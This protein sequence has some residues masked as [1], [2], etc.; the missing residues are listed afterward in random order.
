V[1]RLLFYLTLVL[2]L[3]LGACAQPPQPTD[4]ETPDD[5]SATAFGGT[6]L[7]GLY[8]NNMDFTGTT[9]TRVDTTISKAWTGTGSPI[10]GIAGTT[11]SIRWTGQVVPSYSEEYTFYLTH[12]DGARLMVNGQVLVN[13]W[14]DQAQVVDSGKVTLQAGVKYDIRLEYYRNATNPGQIKME[15]QSARR[16]RQIVPADNLF[17]T[18]SNAQVVIGILKQ[19]TKF[20]S[21]GV[22]LDEAK[23]VSLPRRIEKGRKNC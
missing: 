17:P 18:G 9:A 19:N 5:L 15:W 3:I 11:Y 1:K 4:P 2:V 22:T 13:N 21:L 10:S 6:G 12:T 14:K 16:A 20:S 23:G 7:T 8:F